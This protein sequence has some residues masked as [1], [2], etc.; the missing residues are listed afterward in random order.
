MMPERAIP[1]RLPSS[2]AVWRGPSGAA[3]S[4][5]QGFC[6]LLCAMSDHQDP[7]NELFF[8]QLNESIRSLRTMLRTEVLDAVC[9]CA[10]IGC[11]APVTLPFGEFDRIRSAARRFIVS[12]GHVVPA[13]EF[14][15][16]RHEG[17]LV[18]EKAEL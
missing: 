13:L 5:R 7:R 9:E 18:V 14:V 11:F 6:V 2:P 3:E 4:I 12:P 10:D 16:E 8:R 17:F 15:V 1:G